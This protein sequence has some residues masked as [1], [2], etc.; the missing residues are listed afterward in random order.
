[1]KFLKENDKFNVNQFNLNK[2]DRYIHN[3]KFIKF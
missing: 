1:M 3:K 2:L